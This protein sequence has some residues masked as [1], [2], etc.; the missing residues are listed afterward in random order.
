MVGSAPCFRCREGKE[1]VR[2]GGKQGKHA[3]TRWVAWRVE[4]IGGTN[5]TALEA[6]RA[7]TVRDRRMV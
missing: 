4:G 5:A 3:L 1:N 2:N 7:L 6:S